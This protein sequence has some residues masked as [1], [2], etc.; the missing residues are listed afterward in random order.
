MKKSVEAQPVGVGF[1]LFWQRQ[2]RQQHTG[3]AREHRPAVAALAGNERAYLGELKSRL[4]TLL[5]KNDA[6]RA[7]LAQ[8][9]TEVARAYSDRF[10]APAVDALAMVDAM[11]SAPQRNDEVLRQLAEKLRPWQAES[12]P[13]GSE[14]TAST[15]IADD[16]A[17]A[18]S[19]RASMV[20]EKT[21]PRPYTYAI[22]HYDERR[23][24][25]QAMLLE[26]LQRQSESG[27]SALELIKILVS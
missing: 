19:V 23:F 8:L 15:F 25:N 10:G 26:L 16:S 2:F 13:T 6:P 18:A 12:A 27:K 3:G 5:A 4:L 7:E 14:H 9:L 22:H 21:E 1:S 20:V 17:A 24:G 11:M